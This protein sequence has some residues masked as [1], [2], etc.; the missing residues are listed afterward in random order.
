MTYVRKNTGTKYCTCGRIKDYRAKQCA[1]CAN[2]SVPKKENGIIIFDDELIK[3]TIL[4]SKSIVEVSKKLGNSRQ[5]ITKYIKRNNINISHF[6]GAVGR[7][8][9][10]ENIF[11]VTNKRMNYSV[12]KYALLYNILKN[13]CSICNCDSMWNKK[14]LTLELHHINGNPFDNRIENI[15]L[16]CP[17]CHSQTDNNKGKNCVGT[18]KRKLCQTLM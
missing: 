3:N 17:N 10:P 8:V 2:V 9:L 14:K 18:E 7:N 13:K 16:L 6:R 15:Q 4:K 1:I 12:K 5:C 11:I